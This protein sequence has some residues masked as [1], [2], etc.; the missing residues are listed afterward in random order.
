[1]KKNFKTSVVASSLRKKNGI[2][3][4]AVVVDQAPGIKLKIWNLGRIMVKDFTLEQLTPGLETWIG[5]S[6]YLQEISDL[7][8]TIMPYIENSGLWPD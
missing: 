1:M 5:L 2:T 4:F 8:S 6:H 3:C 7:V